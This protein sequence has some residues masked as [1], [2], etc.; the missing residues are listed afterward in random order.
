MIIRL[1][2]TVILIVNLDDT[3]QPNMNIPMTN[4]TSHQA[5]WTIS[6]HDINGRQPPP[7]PPLILLLPIDGGVFDFPLS[8]TIDSVDYNLFPKC[9]S[10]V[11]NINQ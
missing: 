2:T 9:V 3:H 10:T 11:Y 5:T 7:P 4:L 6:K 1:T 8:R